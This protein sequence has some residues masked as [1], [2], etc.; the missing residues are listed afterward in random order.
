M[1]TI[2]QIKGAN[3]DFPLTLDANIGFFLV[4]KFYFVYYAQFSTLRQPM[5][6]LSRCLSG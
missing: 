5:L 3:W 1:V 4:F 6:G 2:A